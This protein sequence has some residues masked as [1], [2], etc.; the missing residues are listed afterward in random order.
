MASFPPCQLAGEG[1]NG[2][3]K[4]IPFLEFVWADILR[5][6]APGHTQ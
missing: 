6:V 3:K 5:K 1:T 4:N 2:T